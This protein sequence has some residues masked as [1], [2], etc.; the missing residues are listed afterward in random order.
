MAR[1][2]EL[3]DREA[4]AAARHRRTSADAITASAAVVKSGGESSNGSSSTARTPRSAW[5]QQAW[6]FFDL[7]GELRYAIGFMGSCFSRITL[8]PGVMASDGRSGPAYDDEGNALANRADEATVLLAALR[9]PLGGQAQLLRSFAENLG[10]VGEVYLVGTDAPDQQALEALDQQATR[11]WE[12]LSTDE[13]VP[14]G[15]GASGEYDRVMA[16]GASSKQQLPDDAFV[17]RI[18]RSHPRFSQLATSNVQAVLEILD[19]LVLLTKQVRANAMSRL[20]TAGMYWIPSEINHPDD[21]NPPE[22]SEEDDPWTRDFLEVAATAIKD[23]GSAA[24]KVPVV[25]RAPGERIAQI[26]Y[27]R[28]DTADDA[29]AVA[30]RQEAI[31][32]LAQGLDLPVEVVTGHQS[33]TFANA[34]QIDEA[35]YKAHIEPMAELICDALTTGYLRPMLMASS[36]LEPSSPMPPDVA[37]MVVR[38]DASELVTPPNREQAA[39]DAYGDTRNPNFG[40]SGQSYRHALGFSDG[41]APDDAEVSERVR[42]AQLVNVR[43]TVQGLVPEGADVQSARPDSGTPSTTPT[44]ATAS[45]VEQLTAAAEVTVSRAVERAGARLR[46]KANGRPAVRDQLANVA[47]SDVGAVLGPTLVAALAPDDDLFAGEFT[48]FTRH[49]ADW[50]ARAGHP[51]PGQ[52]AAAALAVVD[53]AAHARLFH[54]AAAVDRSTLEVA[55]G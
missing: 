12:A 19:E 6:A 43:E 28:F 41:D 45:L 50:A 31:Q 27:D 46:S 9:S 23:P 49:A 38:F 47:T 33:T 32:R 52:V 10:C 14:R 4:P 1:A 20:A 42:L 26:R 24:G 35:T 2:A 34:A 15:G 53:A 16:P 7:V 17:V 5:Q 40:I 55:C 3:F 44:S 22:G 51:D 11:R 37:E 29:N 8:E 21:D 48:A 30:K 54:P 25:G 36:G 13:L 39:K 18:W